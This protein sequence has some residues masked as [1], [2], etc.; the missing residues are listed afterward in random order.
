[1]TVA[2]EI[3]NYSYAGDGV[4]TAFPFATFFYKNTDIAVY[5]N[6]V[7]QTAGYVVTGAGVLGGGTV[8]ITPAPAAGVVVDLYRVTK[9]QQNTSYTDGATVFS[10][11]LEPSLDY[12]TRITADT[13]RD[14]DT[15]RTQ[16]T[17]LAASVSAAAASATAAALSATNAAASAATCATLLGS[18]QAIYLGALSANP[19]VAAAGVMYFNTT[20]N[21][22]RVSNGVSWQPVVPGPV[23]S[24]AGKTGNVV[25]VA[26]DISDSG[27]TGRALLQAAT[28]TAAKGILSLVSS[29][30]GLGSVDN[31]SDATKFANTAGRVRDLNAQSGTTYT[32]VLTDAGKLVTGNNAS[33][34]TYTVPP[35]SSVAFPVNTTVINIGQYGAGHIAIAAG[36]G[37]TIR[38]SGS[39][40]KLFGQYSVA[41]LVKIGTDE[42]LLF[43][44]ITT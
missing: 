28:A 2:T 7:L 35:N 31:T 9:I 11:A 41:S 17:I 10:T 38:S 36:A 14:V 34:Q 22:M 23:N 26:A 8:T 40:L 6:S 24:V 4:T 33:A 18:F 15:V 37:V 12:L 20:A 3:T 19:A 30:V 21:E 27:S 29:D 25:L 44:D 32:F 5:L 13:K 42:W 1:M 16:I 43:G 39:K